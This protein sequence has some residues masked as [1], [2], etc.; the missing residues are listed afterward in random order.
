MPYRQKGHEKFKKKR[1]PYIVTK[2]AQTLDGKIA[3]FNGD[4]KWISSEQSRKFSR[5]ERDR[6]DAILI[7]AQTL[8]KDDPRLNGV[9]PRKTLK[10]IVLDA[11]LRTPLNSKIFERMPA[12]S[13]VIATTGKASKTKI[14]RFEDKGILVIV[15]PQKKGRVDLKWLARLLAK[16]GVYAILIEGGARVIGYALQEGLVDEMH[17]YLTP[18]ILG[19]QRALSSVVGRSIKFIKQTIGLQFTQIKKIGNDILIIAHVLGNR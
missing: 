2:S 8:I 12:R 6:F 17:V 7:G 1:L 15:C 16:N 13:C 18:R 4:S 11:S 9:S 5:R 10:K 3:T 14:R 19:D